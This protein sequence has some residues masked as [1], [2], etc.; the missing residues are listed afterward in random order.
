MNRNFRK[1][2]S[3]QITLLAIL[4]GVLG[5]TVGMSV[6]SRSLSDLKQASYVD[7][8]TKALAAAEA[9]AEY[10]LNQI[11]ISPPASGC[12]NSGN[13]VAT[14]QPLDILGTNPALDIKSVTVDMCKSSSGYVNES[15]AAEDVMQVDMTSGAAGNFYVLWENTAQAVEV[16]AI[17]S[18][19]SIR[20]FAFNSGS[21]TSAPWNNNNF[22]NV[23]TAP[24]SISNCPTSGLNYQSPAISTAA[25][26]YLMQLRVKPLGGTA[27][28]QV[29]TDIAGGVE[30]QSYNVVST[31]ETNNN[32]VKKIQVTKD[33]YGNLPAIFDNVIYSGG[34][35]IKN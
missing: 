21:P 4:L 22:T 18:D 33:I 16:T 1:N 28:I 2:R 29:C 7:F 34:S 10:G 25:N 24:G 30:A 27:T 23:N 9:G 20:R 15:V 3:G 12:V 14:G 35:L 6:A 5:L 17:Y 13:L 11:T 19:Y 31:A 8:G 26:P 32:V